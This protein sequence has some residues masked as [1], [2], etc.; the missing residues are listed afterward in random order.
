ME[1]NTKNMSQD[2][3]IKILEY[4][5]NNKNNKISPNNL[6]GTFP[7]LDVK[8]ITNFLNEMRIQKIPVHF[9]KSSRIPSIQYRDGLEDYVNSLKKMNKKVKLH[10]IVEFLSTQSSPTKP[11][12]DSGEIA[13]AFIPELSLNEVNKLCAI[14]IAKDDVMDGTTDQSYAKNMMI[15]VVTPRTR[16]AYL[17]KKYLEED[18]QFDMPIN[19]NIFNVHNLSYAGRDINGEIKQ[20]VNPTLSKKAN[21]KPKWLKW[22]F[23]ILTGL[24]IIVGLIEGIKRIF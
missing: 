8:E 2:E 21:G 3:L 23:W 16:N 14:L 9:F 15:V 7:S 17:S 1:A 6:R 11:D 4:V 10:R 22:I 12:F 20:E 5:C 18:E 19:Q 13:K 24:A